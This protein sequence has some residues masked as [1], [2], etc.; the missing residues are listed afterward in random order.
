MKLESIPFAVIE[1]DQLTESSQSGE[2]GSSSSRTMEAGSVRLRV[3]RYSPE[4]L[5]DHWCDLGHLGYVLEGDVVIELRDGS[6]Y[7]VTAGMSFQIP[8]AKAPH[9]VAS[10]GGARVL[11]VD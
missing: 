5:A 7:V 8:S 1:W 10:R 3:V 11:I 9:R 2:T 4:F 6:E